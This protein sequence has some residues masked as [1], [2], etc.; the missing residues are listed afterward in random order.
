MTGLMLKASRAS[1]Q[2]PIKSVP[3][4]AKLAVTSVM[5]G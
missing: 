1:H 5:M 2:N 4:C 3:T